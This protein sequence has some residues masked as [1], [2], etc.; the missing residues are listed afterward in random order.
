MGQEVVGNEDGLS[1]LHVGA[2][3][4]DGLTHGSSL[5]DEGVGDVEHEARHVPGLVA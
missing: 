5:V 1:V 4:H 2:S 3:R